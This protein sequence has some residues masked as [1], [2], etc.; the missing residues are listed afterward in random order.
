MRGSDGS[1]SFDSS[2][3]GWLIVSCDAGDFARNLS[4]CSWNHVKQIT[5]LSFLPGLQEQNALP[6]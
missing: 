1:V 4:G 5:R 3:T 2:F 6:S